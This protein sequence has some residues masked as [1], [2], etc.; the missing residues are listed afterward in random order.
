MDV[1]GRASAPEDAAN[2]LRPEICG[3]PAIGAL[4]PR[5]NA[6]L[7]LL[8][9]SSPWW[10]TCLRSNPRRTNRQGAGSYREPG[11]GVLHLRWA[12]G[13]GAF[14]IRMFSTPLKRLARNRSTAKYGASHAAAETR[15]EDPPRMDAGVLQAN[16]RCSTPV[17]NA[18]A[19]SLKSGTASRW[20]PYGRAGSFTS[21]T[22]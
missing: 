18:T 14:T 15:L 16:L 4:H 3:G 21:C 10:G 13:A 1:R 11:P 7:A 5:R 2:H 8:E 20:N 9:T 22:N 6:G 17:W 12:I 19:H